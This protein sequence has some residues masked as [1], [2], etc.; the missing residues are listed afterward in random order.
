M[1][2]CIVCVVEFYPRVSMEEQSGSVHNHA[3][4]GNIQRTSK[5]GAF[6]DN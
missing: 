4:D 2:F 3:C 1:R 6:K 5:A